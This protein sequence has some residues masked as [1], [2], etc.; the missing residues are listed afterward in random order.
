MFNNIFNMVMDVKEKTYENIK[1]RMNLALNRDNENIELFNDVLCIVEL[2]FIFVK[3]R[4][5]SFYLFI[6]EWLK[7]LWF[8]DR[9]TSNIARLVNLREYRL[10]E[11]KNHECY[12][13]MQAFIPVYL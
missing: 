1:V 10:Y 7:S 13:F 2:K 11:I 6:Y 12:M 4:M 5:H 9:Y 8:F 3:T